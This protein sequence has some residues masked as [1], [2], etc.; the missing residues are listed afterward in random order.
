MCRKEII[1]YQT[2]LIGQKEDDTTVGKERTS[3][4][5]EKQKQI[6]NDGGKASQANDQSSLASLSDPS[7]QDALA[8]WLQR[9][10][11]L[12][13]SLSLYHEYRE[14]IDL[15]LLPDL[16]K[17]PLRNLLSQDLQQWYRQKQREGYTPQMIERLH[18]ILRQTFDMALSLHLVE[19]NICDM[20]ELLYEAKPAMVAPLSP[21]DVERVCRVLIRI[22]IY[23]EEKDLERL[24][25]QE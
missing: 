7:L 15:Y 13:L 21:L 23:F 19:Q 8:G 20:V 25:C 24:S 5:C 22:A 4:S 12:G 6:M 2:R 16:G 10:A 18:H 11:Q 9:R 14:L 1:A 3:P 17:I